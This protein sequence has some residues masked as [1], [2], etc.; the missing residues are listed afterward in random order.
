[1]TPTTH[2]PPITLK[3]GQWLFLNTL[4]YDLM[5]VAKALDAC[6]ADAAVPERRAR[7]QARPRPKRKAR[8][9]HAK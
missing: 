8:T 1:M 2:M 3:L 9:R 4:A 6:L 5:A 7:S